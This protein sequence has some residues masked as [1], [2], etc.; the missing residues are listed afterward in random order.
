MINWENRSTWT[1]CRMVFSW[2]LTIIVCV[3]SYILFGFIQLEQNSLFSDYNYG[4][5]CDVLYTSVQLSVFDVTLGA[6]SQ[7]Y[8]TCICKNQSMFVLTAS[9]SDYC[10]TWRRQYILYLTIPLLISLGIVIYNI[11]VSFLF[12]LFSKF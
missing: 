9:E 12:K 7:E 11:I 8:L 4:I 2:L 5:D 1:T 3:G 10:S 6:T